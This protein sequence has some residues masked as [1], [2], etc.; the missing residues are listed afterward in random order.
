MTQATDFSVPTTGPAGPDVMYGRI[1]DNFVAALSGHSGVSRPSY[2]VPGTIWQDTAVAG[3]VKL[4]FY[5]GTDDV[6]LYT[7]DT[8]T[9]ALTVPGFAAGG[10][11]AM[12]GN[13][14]TNPAGEWLRG[15]IDG[16]KLSNNGSDATNDIDV[17]TGSAGSRE[18][19]PRLMTLTGTL[20]K[21]LDA[22][23]S[24]GTGNGMRWS[25]EAIANKTYHVFLGTKSDGSDGDVF[26]YPGTAGV[27]ADTEAFAATVLAA[28]QGEAGGASYEGVRRIGSILRSAGAIVPFKQ[29][30]D[31]FYRDVRVNDVN[32]NNPGIS[33]VTRTLSIPTGVEFAAF[34]TVQIELNTT[35]IVALSALITALAQT[36]SDPDAVGGTVTLRAMSAGGAQRAISSFLVP[37]NTSAQVRSRLNISGA[38]TTLLLH[39]DGWIDTRGKR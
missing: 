1:H 14:I 12:A 32:A 5:D 21:R 7:I 35:S 15:H 28:W 18:A 20:T 2:A 6:L 26:A 25:G 13:A 29:Y 24:A 39:T 38:A 22:N 11:I 17:G 10:P 23:W 19:T 33:A 3:L 34:G 8:S 4:Y 27:D 31:Y 37:T 9:S 16:L 36:D 30:G